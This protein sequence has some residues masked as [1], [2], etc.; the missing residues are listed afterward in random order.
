MIALSV[1]ASLPIT[2]V[3]YG[4]EWV[5]L[6]FSASPQHIVQWVALIFRRTLHI[7]LVYK[8]KVTTSSSPT[9]SSQHNSPV[10]IIVIFN[11]SHTQGVIK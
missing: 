4:Q 5:M 11:Y 8:V 1:Y 6:P 9:Y 10:T 3:P 2:G 7:F